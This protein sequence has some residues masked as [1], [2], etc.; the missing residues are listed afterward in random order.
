MVKIG[1]AEINMDPFALVI[2]SRA[3]AIGAFAVKRVLPYSKRRTVGPFIFLDHMGPIQVGPS[4]NFDVKPHPHIGLSTITYLFSGRLLHRDSLGSEQWIVPG[5]V[6]WM[7]AGSGIVHSERFPKSDPTREAFEGLQVWVALPA[8]YEEISPQFQHH[9]RAE[10]P[11]FDLNGAKVHLIIGEAFGRTSPVKTFSR[12]FYLDVTLPKGKTLDLPLG[13]QECGVYLVHG[14]VAVEEFPVKVNELAVLKS[15]SSLRITAPVVASRF[16][17]LG[18]ETLAE[19]RYI[20]WNFVSSRVDRIEDAKK[21]WAAGA[22]PKIPNDALEF[23]P[24]PEGEI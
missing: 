16:M 1:D 8:Q 9:P 15:K 17:V 4:D 10:L 14:G 12:M 11:I 13:G 2:P 21:K 24:L 20:W 19:P 5:D 3:R 7:T 22:F 18:G 23:V 6:N